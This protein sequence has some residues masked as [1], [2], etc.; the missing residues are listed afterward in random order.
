MDGSN[1]VATKDSADAAPK[2]V[3]AAS[4]EELPESQSHPVAYSKAN[5]GLSIEQPTWANAIGVESFPFSECVLE[6]TLLAAAPG[7]EVSQ[8]AFAFFTHGLKEMAPKDAVEAMLSLQMLT[9]R[10]QM[11]RAART[12]GAAASLPEME[13]ASSITNQLAR[14]F[15]TQTESRKRYRN[16]Q[17]GNVTVKNMTVEEGGQAVV[18]NVTR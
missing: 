14:T 16:P 17:T 15:A 3:V 18:G 2:T 13:K 6:Q 1:A 11:M 4:F 7:N 12:L 5:G 9:I 10:Q 8:K